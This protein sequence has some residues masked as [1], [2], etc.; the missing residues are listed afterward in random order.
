MRPI[1]T[2]WGLPRTPDLDSDSKLGLLPAPYVL[3]SAYL[4]VLTL[5]AP[6]SPTRDLC[7]RVAWMIQMS[8]N[9]IR[10]PGSSFRV[11]YLPHLQARAFLTGPECPV[12]LL[13]PPL[14][15]FL[16]VGVDLH[17]SVPDLFVQ[18]DLS[19]SC[20]CI[21]AT[22][23]GLCKMFSEQP[24]GT[25]VYLVFCFLFGAATMCDTLPIFSFLLP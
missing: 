5:L 13:M 23:S 10:F 8:L 24:Q 17:L 15:S 14:I 20:I 22:W 6:L 21:L 7:L 3:S 11:S 9:S 25:F 19:V 1:I 2:G 4:S 16:L 18:C 12:G